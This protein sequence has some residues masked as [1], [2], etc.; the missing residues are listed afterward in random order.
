MTIRLFSVA[1]LLVVATALSACGKREPFRPVV[2]IPQ[3]DQFSNAISVDE[4]AGTYTMET[5]FPLEPDR[6]SMRRIVE[7]NGGLRTDTH[8]WFTDFL[9]GNN[10]HA[11]E[12]STAR[13]ELKIEILKYRMSREQA[14]IGYET[15]FVYKLVSVATG[16]AV[17]TE[18]IKDRGLQPY[19]LAVG[20]RLGGAIGSALAGG[21]APAASSVTGDDIR[22]SMLKTYP[23]V[24]RSNAE[25]YVRHLRSA[26]PQPASPG[27]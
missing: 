10:L 15:D 7:R 3:A 4:P 1:V 19:D 8:A 5:V 11:K 25:I 20:S 22:F 27:G 14:G 24:I 21:S 12:K 9:I 23:I 26:M 17:H 6:D 2:D 16:E 18:E 13:F